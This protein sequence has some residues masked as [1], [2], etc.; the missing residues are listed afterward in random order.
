MK[1]CGHIWR[2]RELIVDD[3]VSRLQDALIHGALRCIRIGHQ[4]RG[5]IPLPMQFAV[6]KG[7]NLIRAWQPWHLQ[8]QT[9]QGLVYSGDDL[10]G[11]A[12]D[13]CMRHNYSGQVTHGRP[14]IMVVSLP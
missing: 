3:D 11:V 2:E 12:N 13:V 9:N 8:T 10:H 7:R 1:A 4:L 5:L 14:R 6:Y